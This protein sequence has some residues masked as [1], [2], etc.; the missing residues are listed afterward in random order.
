MSEKKRI[1][2][3][4]IDAGFGHRSAANAVRDAILDQYARSAASRW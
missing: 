3:L 2:I 1:L 4:T